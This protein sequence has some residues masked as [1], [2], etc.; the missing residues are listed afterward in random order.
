MAPYDRSKARAEIMEMFQPLL[1]DPSVTSSSERHL[2]ALR[3][4]ADSLPAVLKPTKMQLE[5]AHYVGIDLIPSPSLRDRLVNVTAE[6]AQN[7]INDVGINGGE[8]EDMG[9]LI[10]W[11]DDALN[12]VSWEFSQTTLERWGWL[13]GR[14]WVARTNF[15][16]RQRGVAALPDW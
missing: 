12:E 16:R 9:Q 10:I 13:L 2:L 3:S 14:E 4:L 6:I 1:S 7:F 11:G 8:H 15:W 5:K